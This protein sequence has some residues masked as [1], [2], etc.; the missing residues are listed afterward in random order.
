MSRKVV[1][2][3]MGSVSPLG[4][5]CQQLTESIR[6]GTSG[7]DFITD[8]DTT[9]FAVKFAGQVKNFDPAVI[10]YDQKVV[11][12][13]DP[14][15]HYILAASIEAIDSSQLLSSQSLDK[16]K[17]GVILGSGIGGLTTI[18]ENTLKN[19]AR[20]PRRI[21]PS[22]I[23]S[24]IINMPSGHISIKYG[25]QGPNLATTTACTT[26]THCIAQAFDMIKADYADVMIAGSGEKASTPMGIGGFASAKALS[27]CNE[28]PQ[29]ACKPWDINRDGFVLSDGAATI[30][31]EEEQHAIER[32]AN[33]LAEVVSV[34]Y[35]ADAYHMTSPHAEGLGAKL[36]MEQALT[37]GSVHYSDIDHIN[38][39]STSTVAGD[40]LELEAIKKVFKEHSKT[41]SLTS[42]KSMTGHL[43][44]AAGSLEAII[45][46]LSLQHQ[47]IPPTINVT[48]PDPLCE[49]FNINFAKQATN[50]DIT[51]ILSNSFGFGGTNGCLILK[52]YS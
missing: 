29:S 45:S 1:I 49:Q 34:G 46:I 48:N 22:F 28:N 7:I 43:L 8:F 42:T 40:L 21:A 24:T 50:G 51:T 5:N 36:A 14:F 44:G 3:G 6:L 11:A 35:S 18:E 16:T 15:M 47:M 20:G 27:T 41:V 33:I 19:H 23:P 30:V 9:D 38:T 17:V 32:G 31:L 4:L 25:F 37:R 39:H 26:G 12:R 52:K 10:D 13:V 2:T